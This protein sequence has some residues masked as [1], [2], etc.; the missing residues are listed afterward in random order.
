K[1]ITDQIPGLKKQNLKYRDYAQK[2]IQDLF[3]KEILEQSIV[4]QLAFTSS[5]V[6]LSDVKANVTQI[7]LPDEVQFS[8]VNTAKCID[9][10]GDNWPDLILGGNANDFLPQFGR[11]DASEGHVLLNN[12]KGNF[13]YLSSDK[14]GL[15]ARGVTRNIQ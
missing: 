8:C 2:S 14:S 3:P 1:E 11:L 13:H 10:N 9:L 15:K 6:A 12:G 7:R 5:I 4:K